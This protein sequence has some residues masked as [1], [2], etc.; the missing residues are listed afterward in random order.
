MVRLQSTIASSLAAARQALAPDG[1]L[2][3]GVNLSNFLLVSER[4]PG[5]EPRGV[6]PSLCG[7][8]ARRLGA[9]LEVVPYANPGLL[10]DGAARGE[11]AVGL[12]GAEPARAE[13]I[14]FTPP[15]AEIEATF[16]VPPSSRLGDIASVDA[17]GTRVCVS[18]RAAYCLWLEANLE[19]ADLVQTSEPGLALSADLFV[20]EACDALAGLRPWLLG[21][22]DQDPRFEGCSVLDGNFS[23]VQ[24]AVGTPRVGGAETA[25]L[26]FLEAFVAD[27]TASG[28]VAKL[29]ADHGVA[30]KLAVASRSGE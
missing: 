26:P 11:W 3:A 8:L 1:V 4:G 2:R 15:Y 16:L 24:Q 22:V 9:E 21:L 6:S 25:A 28:L 27:A 19:R 23:T 17:P 7:E 14:L 20:D 18:R 30:G 12:I 5:G 10:A 13:T 29:I